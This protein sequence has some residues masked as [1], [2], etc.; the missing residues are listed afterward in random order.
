MKGRRTTAGGGSYTKNARKGLC[1]SWG[2]EAGAGKKRVGGAGVSAEVGLRAGRRTPSRGN[3]EQ[4]SEEGI[5][6]LPGMARKPGEDEGRASWTSLA[7]GAPWEDG[8]RQ[9]G[10][11][12]TIAG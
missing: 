9:N 2:A 3:R 4:M 10:R 11:I 7:P 12:S 1:S 6:V 5:G 8:R